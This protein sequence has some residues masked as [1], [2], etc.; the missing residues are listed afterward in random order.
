VGELLITARNSLAFLV[1]ERLLKLAFAR[2][3]SLEQ[4]RVLDGD[5]DLV[6][7][8]LEQFNLSINEWADS[9]PSDCN[10]A[11]DLTVMH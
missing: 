5:D 11:D 7:E 10:R 4:P 1:S 9:G 2:L 8:Y 6:G 3:L